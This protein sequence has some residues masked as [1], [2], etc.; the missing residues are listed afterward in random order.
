MNAKDVKPQPPIK[1][2]LDKERS[3]HYDLNAFI[4]LE[5]YYGDVDSAL[6]AFETGSM[7][8]LR[9]VLWAGLIHEDDSLTPKDV[10]VLVMVS[11]VE[12]ITA[13]MMEALE[14]GMPAG[15]PEGNARPPETG[16]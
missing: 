15:A 14:R 10:G 8:A 7:K 2:Q 13:A 3:L 11:D 16:E 1:V 4:A 5:E 12:R 6:A 9:S